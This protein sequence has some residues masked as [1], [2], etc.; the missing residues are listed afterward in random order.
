MKEALIAYFNRVYLLSETERALFRQAF[1]PQSYAAKD[2]LLPQ[3]EVCQKLFFITKGVVRVGLTDQRG[4]EIT[5]YFQ[6]ENSFVTDYESFLRNSGAHFFIQALEDTAVLMVDRYGLRQLYE[7]TPGGN[8]IGRVMAEELFIATN[9]RLL[10]FYTQS[11]EERYRA[12]L[13]TYPGLANRVP[14]GYI[15]SYVGVKPQSLSRIKRRF[16]Q[17]SAS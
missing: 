11:P 4:E 1:V 17:E 3:G 7:Q 10:S 13:S 6:A 5:V 15:A 8:I 16:Q 14:Q 9:Q 2:F 12:L